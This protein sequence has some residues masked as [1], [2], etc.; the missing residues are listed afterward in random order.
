MILVVSDIHLG[1]IKTNVDDFLNFLNEFGSSDVVDHL[2]ILGDFF[3]F[4]KRSFIKIITENNQ[5]I[6][7]LDNFSKVNYVVGNHD[8]N[9]LN[10]Y[11]NYEVDFPFEVS[12]S[13]KL[14]DGDNNFYFIHGYEMELL[15]LL[16]SAA[17]PIRKTDFLENLDMYEKCSQK[18]CKGELFSGGIVE[19]LNLYD[20]ADEALKTN[21]PQGVVFTLLRK[22]IKRISPN[23]E[24]ELITHMLKYPS[25]R[26]NLT[27]EEF[28]FP[29]NV[30]YPIYKKYFLGCK[31]DDIVVFGHTHTPFYD[32]INKFA[33]T[34]SWVDELPKEM[35]NSY[36]K[37]SEGVMELEF[38]KNEF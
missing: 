18:L 17:Y 2:I 38:Y 31:S 27:S 36:I 30:L 7:L 6:D 8:Y 12:K 16:Q 1:S 5:I 23:P 4:W 35:Q 20:F 25:Q 29:G 21:S 15:W 34:G 9:M 32:K 10:Y 26:L 28:G 13:L 14:K 3:E 37:I 11:E 19:Y 33:N 24:I 22:L